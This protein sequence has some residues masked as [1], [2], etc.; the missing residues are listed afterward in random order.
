MR[1][2]EKVGIV[3]RHMAVIACVL[4]VIAYTL[5]VTWIRHHR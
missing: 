1:E 2:E 4:F 3:R 5:V